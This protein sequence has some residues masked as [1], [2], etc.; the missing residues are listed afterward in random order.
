M[1]DPNGRKKNK[2]SIEIAASV[3][4]SSK[5][6]E[7]TAKLVARQGHGFA[8]EQANNLYDQLM[9]N[10]SVL[11]GDSNILNG[12]DRLVNGMPVQCKYWESGP[13]SIQACFKNGKFKYVN[14]DGTLQQIEVPK[15]QY[16]SAVKA[17]ERRIRR[18]EL[19][20]TKNPDDAKQIIRQGHVS[21]E[22]ALEM[23]KPGKIEGIKLDIGN[24]LI[25][26]TYAFGI[27]SLATFAY[28]I[29]DGKTTKE[30][31]K[32]S[33]YAGIK[34]GGVTLMSQVLT[35]QL[36]RTGLHKSLESTMNNWV[37]KLKTNSGL[38]KT[39]SKNAIVAL[40][41]I[42]VLTGF[43]LMKFIQKRISGNQFF[44]NV[45]ITSV[46]VAGGIAGG[47]CRC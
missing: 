27:S 9:G 5:A 1:D 45:V 28:C 13:K 42:I 33:V 17:M 3:T 7:E 30:A 11:V 40:A 29:W 32:K 26:S 20:M 31:I 18:G 38:S 37:P 15:D 36:M 24:S 6:A 44:K 35:R 12:P 8:A 22:Q 14:E 21:R 25:V 10:K 41:T 23:V 34:V 16:D 43:E 46:G 4:A 2:K 47:G 19:P 39:I